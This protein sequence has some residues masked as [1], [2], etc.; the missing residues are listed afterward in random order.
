MHF[1]SLAREKYLIVDDYNH[2]V[3]FFSHIDE[4]RP[5]KIHCY[6]LNSP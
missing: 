3:H 5:S 1:P 6:Y 2:Q 4:K